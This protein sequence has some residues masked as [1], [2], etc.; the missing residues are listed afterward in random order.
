MAVWRFEGF[1]KGIMVNTQLDSLEDKQVYYLSYHSLLFSFILSFLEKYSKRK[2]REGREIREGEKEELEAKE[3]EET[4]SKFSSH[5][6]LSQVII[7]LLN[8]VGS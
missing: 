5:L 4:S 8:K 6:I 3:M 2:K 7:F 1:D